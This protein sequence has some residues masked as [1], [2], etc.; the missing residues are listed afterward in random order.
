MKHII[1]D[2]IPIGY[3]YDSLG[4]VLCRMIGRG[5]EVKLRNGQEIPK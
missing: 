3:T 5:Y 2:D 4:N 1:R